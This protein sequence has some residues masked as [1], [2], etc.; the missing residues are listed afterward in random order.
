MATPVPANMEVWR[1]VLLRKNACEFLVFETDSAL[2]L[3]TVEIPAYSRVA[4]ELNSRIKTLWGLDVYSLYP[5]PSAD[6]PQPTR[7]YVVEALPF[8]DAAPE[9]ARWI[10]L[11][12]VENFFHSDRSD[13][14]AIQTWRASLSERNTN[15]SLRPFEKPGWLFALKDLLQDALRKIPLTINENF[16]QFTAGTSCSLIRFE[17]N[18]EAVWFKAVDEPNSRE[19]P[20]TVLLSSKLQGYLPRILATQP[21]WNAWVMPAIPGIPLSEAEDSSVWYNA[22][23]DLARLQIASVGIVGD[24]LELEP[25]DVRTET[26]L[27]RIQPFFA[28]VGML[29][30]QQTKSAPPRVLP[31]ELETLESDTREALLAL[32]RE[33]VPDTVGNLDLNPDNVIALPQSTVFLDWAEASVG[34]PFFSLAHLLEHRRAS[35]T[36]PEKGDD[37][38]LVATYLA[39]CVKHW[40]L[41]NPNRILCLAVFLAVFAH[42]VSTD[43]WRDG[44]A[45]R[46]SRLA[47]YYRSL[48]RRMKSYA[49]R[50]R[51]G[52]S[53]ASEMFG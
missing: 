32:Q 4:L 51:N 24:V 52:A 41:S 23:R 27:E 46:D 47:G 19:F 22:A 26:L 12:D 33:P 3:P 2:R 53:C 18:R 35:A 11:Y 7:Y 6:G 50:L 45:L 48:T 29:M 36:S 44:R 17:T 28:V 16:V 34:H 37:D 25:R 5:I 40:S 10:S 42:A 31:S 9:T 21:N 30:E 8:G 49:D 20:L 15:G 38:R 1:I 14:A 13:F 43:A 39:E